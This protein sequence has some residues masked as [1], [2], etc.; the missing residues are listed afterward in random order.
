MIPN[1]NNNRGL[2][3]PGLKTMMND[4]HANNMMFDGEAIE[5]DEEWNKPKE[6]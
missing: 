6:S 4:T 5:E 2:Y 3:Y 1:S